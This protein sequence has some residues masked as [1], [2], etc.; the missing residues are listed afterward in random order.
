MPCLEISIPKLSP[1]Q[2]EKLVG[3]LTSDFEQYANYDVEA[4][5][6]RFYEYD[7]SE[8][9]NAGKLWDG[10]TGKPYIHFKMLIPAR[11][12]SEKSKMIRAFTKSLTETLGNPDWAP[13]IYFIEPD[14]D[15]IGFGGK[16]LAE[17]KR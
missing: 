5:G 2:K 7:V 11:T 12:K 3:R 9:A 1:D 4:F 8:S 15:S 10:K 17:H 6:I 13:V 14:D 16:S